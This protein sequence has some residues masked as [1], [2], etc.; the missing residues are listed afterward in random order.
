MRTWV[1]LVAA[2]SV[3]AAGAQ[4]SGV[5]VQTVADPQV[6]SAPLYT[7]SEVG[8]E[9]RRQALARLAPKAVVER[10][11]VTAATCAQSVQTALN[12]GAYQVFVERQG[13][14]PALAPLQFSMAFRD[15]VDVPRIQPVCQVAT[16]L[17]VVKLPSDAL[18]STDATSRRDYILALTLADWAQA[19]ADN[20]PP[21]GGDFPPDVTADPLGA[22]SRAR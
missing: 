5:T 14:G 2:L 9:D 13:Q 8:V 22:M 7:F 1:L 10:K 11:P 17:V 3:G 19:K 21:L 16:G 20:R 18:S 4:E 12:E 15:T 6:E